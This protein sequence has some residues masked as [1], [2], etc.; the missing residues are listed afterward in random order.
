M[1]FACDV[2][3]GKLAKYLRFLGFDAEYA[4]NEASFSRILFLEPDR[5]PLS[6]KS[7]ITHQK[8]MRIYSEIPSEQILEL[9]GFISLEL[10]KAKVL[11]RCIECNTLLTHAA[12]Q[13]IEPFVP[14]FV[15]HQYRD[16]KTCSVCHKVYWKGSHVQNIDKLLQELF[17]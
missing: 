3:L 1:R 13:E 7:T 15:F 5:I 4:G 9:K 14:E 10:D 6:R 17:F 16:F 8:H 2:M 11:T 12:K